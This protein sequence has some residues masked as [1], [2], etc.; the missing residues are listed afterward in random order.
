MNFVLKIFDLEQVARHTGAVSLKHGPLEHE[1]LEHEP[2]TC[3]PMPPGMPPARLSEPLPSLLRF[4]EDLPLQA[5]L[6]TATRLMGAYGE[7]T[8]RKAGLKVS[9]SGLGV[10]R[11]LVAED[12]L[13]AS[14]VA[15]R[16][17]SN[18][19]TLTSVVN[20][21]VKDGFVV[22]KADDA[23]RRVV[24]LYLTEPGRAVVTYY[25]TQ[26]APMWRKAFA[27]VDA[28]D[29][30]V[31]RRFFAEMIGHLGQLIDEERGK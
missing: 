1:P 20:T 29:E 4:P 26:A 12:G 21:L 27:F 30:P 17:W 5:L 25:V 14:E 8:A 16:A 11:V 6:L 13:K 18:P 28:A 19:A 2:A 10:L 24:R 23:D 31:V 15:D 9:L 22:R 7:W 3:A